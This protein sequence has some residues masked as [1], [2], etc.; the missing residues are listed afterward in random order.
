MAV[1]QL[2]R[3]DDDG[4]VLGQSTADLIG[5]YGTSTPVAQPS[6]AAQQLIT[7]ASG[8]TGAPSNGILTI[9]ASYNSTILANA[10]KTLSD[11][12]NA[13]RNALVSVNLMKGSS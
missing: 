13:C 6:G 2:S 11:G 4:T 12:V 5:F 3:G 10:I 9:T 7:D 8:G 1:R